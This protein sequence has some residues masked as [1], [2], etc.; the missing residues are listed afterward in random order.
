M[1]AAQDVY[2]RCK[3]LGVNAIHVKVRGRGGIDT[4]TPGPGAQA[5]MRSLAR[6][7]KK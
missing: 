4:R 2:A 3:L 5:A 1:M 6:L 7:G